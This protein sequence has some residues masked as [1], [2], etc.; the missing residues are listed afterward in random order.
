MSCIRASFIPSWRT[1]LSA[2]A[3]NRLRRCVGLIPSEE[4]LSTQFRRPGTVNAIGPACCSRHASTT[5]ASASAF[6]S[7]HSSSPVN[8]ERSHSPD[9]LTRVFEGRR[10]S[11]TP[12]LFHLQTAPSRHN[13]AEFAQFCAT[14][15]ASDRFQYCRGRDRGPSGQRHAA[16]SS[17]RRRG[18]PARLR[19]GSPCSPPTRAAARRP[20]WN[21]SSRSRWPTP[22]RSRCREAAAR[23]S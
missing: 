1:S 11:S 14:R 23:C 9:L 6:S 10:G 13:F 8:R 21:G 15:R 4:Y 16:R 19:A 5:P 17:R 12:P 22:R 18:R 2:I 20:T 3:V 7:S